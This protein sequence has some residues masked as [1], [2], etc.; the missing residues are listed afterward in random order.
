MILQMGIKGGETKLS[1]YSQEIEE[2]SDLVMTQRRVEEMP[3]LI[4][5]SN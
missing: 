5:S 4:S 2:D 1:R 3:N